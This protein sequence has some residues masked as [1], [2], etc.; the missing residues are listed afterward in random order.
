MQR[1]P[2]ASASTPAPLSVSPFPSAGEASAPAASGEALR[3]TA[4]ARIPTRYGEFQLHH[5]EDPA[6]GKEHLALTLGQVAGRSGVLT[7]IHSECFTGDVLGSQRC[8]CG[9]QLASA[10]QTI[11]EAGQ[12][13]IVYLRQE[14]RGI[15]L[16][17]KLRAYNLQDQGYDTVD[18]NLLLGHGADERDYAPAAAILAALG[19]RSVRLLTNNPSKIEGLQALGVRVDERVPLQAH[20]NRENAG[21]L[22][23][24][25]LRMGHLLDPAR[26]APNGNGVH[27]GVTSRENP[28]SQPP[29]LSLLV[30]LEQ[31]MRAQARSDAPFVTLSYAQTL[32]GSIAAR[33]GEHLAISGPESM[34]LTHRLRAIH[35]AILVGV[36]TVLADD[37]QLTVR[38]V[39]GP[40]PRPVI[41]D[42]RL[43]TPPTAR[44]LK[45]GRA[46]IIVAVQG[47]P[48]ERAACLE[49]AGARVL[50]LPGDGT[51]RVSLPALLAWLKQESLPSL[52]VEGGAQVLTSFLQARLADYAVVTISP[53]Y[54]GG[55]RAV[56]Q[57][58]DGQALP[59]LRD[60]QALQVGPDV[61][62]WGALG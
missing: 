3:P 19:V 58:L 49:Q 37:P 61:T 12:G 46:P 33:P 34:A 47:A 1:T 48:E 14:G 5:F 16:S 8:D 32:D 60:P 36:N 4:S 20:A 50:F 10:M 42:S 29:Y 17:E 18:A 21:Y 54:V 2:Q 51:G 44:L 26:L 38:L 41:L 22:R 57:P 45:A 39:D 59:H 40:S 9:E 15:G 56:Q 62:L 28:A 7:R 55:Y 52:M 35:A 31:R 23:T 13:V 24:K 11:A 27:K 30:N 43:R 25:M 53:T 6:S